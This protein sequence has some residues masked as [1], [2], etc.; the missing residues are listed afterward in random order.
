MLRSALTYLTVLI[1]VAA[2]G[3]ARGQ[4][5]EEFFRG[6]QLSLIIGYNPGGSYDAYGRIAANFLPRFIPGNPSIVPKNM[7]G[8]GSVKAANARAVALSRE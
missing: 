5:A 1:A 4:T 6:K 3:Q 2:G 8:V 7:P